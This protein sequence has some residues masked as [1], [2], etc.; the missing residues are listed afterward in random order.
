M[1]TMTNPQAVSHTSGSI[2]VLAF[3]LLAELPKSENLVFSPLGIYCLLAMLY[4]GAETDTRGAIARFISQDPKKPLAVTVHSLLAELYSRTELTADELLGI[5]EA[6]AERTALLESGE[7]G[8]EQAEFAE[9]FY[10]NATADDLRLQLSVSNGMWVA[11]CYPYRRDFAEILHAELAAEV[12]PLDFASDPGGAC[13]AIN[14]WVHDRTHGKITTVVAPEQLSPLTRL[15]LTNTVYFKGR[16]QEEFSAP[17]PGPFYLLDGSCVEARMMKRAFWG[18]NWVRHDEYW[19]VELPYFNRPLSMVIIV[20]SAPGQEAL[21][22]LERGL[23]R[24]WPVVSHESS[25]EWQQVNLT[26]PEF[27]FTGGDFRRKRGLLE[28]KR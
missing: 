5:G 27:R 2:T 8:E 17:A 28:D 6:E 26:V 16:W 1:N 9:R 21:H 24:N 14:D 13:K 10:G 7:W 25:T 23:R 18:L 3:D 12:R 4:E 15:I 19:A 11:E 22:D 20:P